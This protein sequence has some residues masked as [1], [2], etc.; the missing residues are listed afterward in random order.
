MF[1]PKVVFDS[2][3]SGRFKKSTRTTQRSVP[4]LGY[5]GEYV[6]YEQEITINVKY[7][8]QQLFEKTRPISL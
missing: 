5:E 4:L 1:L 7:M 6:V 2:S 8:V 3:M